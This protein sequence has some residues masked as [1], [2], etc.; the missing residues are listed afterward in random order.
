MNVELARQL[1]L[2]SGDRVLGRWQNGSTYYPG[3]VQQV[4]KERIKIIYDDGDV[5]WTSPGFTILAAEEKS[6]EPALC[7]DKAKQQ[8]IRIEVLELAP[9]PAQPRGSGKDSQPI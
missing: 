7:L 4:E 6:E 1:L 9:L 2:K 3:R 8:S 5:E